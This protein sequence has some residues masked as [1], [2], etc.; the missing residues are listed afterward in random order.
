MADA[1]QMSE[2]VSSCT[3]TGKKIT[4]IKKCSICF[5][6]LVLVTYMHSV[7]IN[8]DIAGNKHNISFQMYLFSITRDQE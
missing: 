3:R 2:Y 8:L 4:C 6:F 1:A 7:L 5:L